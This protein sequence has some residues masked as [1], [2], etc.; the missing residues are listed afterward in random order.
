M[1]KINHTE[2]NS[3][4]SFVGIASFITSYARMKLIGLIKQAGRENCYYMDTDSLFV[5]E[6]GLRR[7]MPE[8][9]PYELGKLKVEEFSD[10]SAFW[11]PKFYLFN[12][13]LK[14]KG[15]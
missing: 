2:K 5:N 11:A 14:C 8:I 12:D 6:D 15:C 10:K 7:L 13:N 3:Y 1:Y 4:D 9:D